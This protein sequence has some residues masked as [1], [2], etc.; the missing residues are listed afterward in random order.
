MS[1][2]S[3]PVLLVSSN[4]SG[5]GGGERYLVFLASGLAELGVEAHALLSTSGYMDGW[6]RDLQAVGA[7]V[8]RRE[9]RGLAQRRLRFVQALSDRAQIN[10]VAEVCRSVDPRGIV[11][12]QQYDEDGLDYVTG[13]LRAA[14]APVAGVMHMPMTADKLS[15]PFGRWR[16]MAVARWYANHPYRLILVSDGARD[17]FEACYPHPRP[18]NVVNN[19]VPLAG[20]HPPHPGA[21]RRGDGSPVIAFVGQFVPQKNLNMLVD[22]WLTIRAS[23]NRSRLLLVGDGPLRLELE[24]R[25]AAEREPGS[26]TIT[27]WTDQPEGHLDG[28]DLFVMSSHF[29]G[30]PLSLVEAAARGIRCVVTPFNGARDVARH[31]PWV[32]VQVDFRP[33][34][35]RLGI[36]HALVRL[37]EESLP[38]SNQIALFRDFFSVR[39]MA[40]EILDVLTRST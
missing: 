9:L 24:Q 13:A 12:N 34:T 30:L 14:C 40:G 4:S 11:I 10:T 1:L 15:R 26:W 23:G 8:H 2:G 31:A 36:E 28:V 18:T 32:D 27:G 29:E 3:R 39:R 19:G 7:V 6:A 5:H 21:A 22:A 16:R 25:L 35:F 17:E 37:E 38:T 20:V 33:E